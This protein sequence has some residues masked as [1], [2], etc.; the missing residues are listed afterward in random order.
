MG[1]CFT[2]HNCINTLCMGKCFT[3]HNC[4]NTL[5]M[6]KCFTVHNCIN[7]LCMGKCFTNIHNAQNTSFDKQQV[8]A[9]IFFNTFCR[10]LCICVNQDNQDG[11]HQSTK[12]NL[13]ERVGKTFLAHLAERSEFLPSLCV[14]PIFTFESSLK[15]FGQMNR[16]LV[17]SIY[18]R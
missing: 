9:S 15:L 16:K 1:K 11:C 5:C 8:L 3:V 10:N 18:G 12:F 7:T 13:L 4:I 6:G 2:V 17:G 14:C